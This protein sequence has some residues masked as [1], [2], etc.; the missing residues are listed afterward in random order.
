MLYWK[1]GVSILYQDGPTGM[2]YFR[3]G[4]ELG[5]RLQYTAGTER[6]LSGIAVGFAVN[7]KPDSALVYI[8]QAIPW[9]K[10]AGENKRLSLAYIN[11]ADAYSLLSDFSAAL[12]ACDTALFYANQLPAKEEALGH[13][14]GIISKIYID[15][16]QYALAQVNLEKSIQNFEKTTNRRMV[17]QLY[18]DKADLYNL[19][20]QPAKALPWL[21]EATRIGDSLNDKENLTAYHISFI[22]TYA[23]LKRYDDARNAARQAILI[24]DETDN[25][26]QKANVYLNLCE[27]EKTNNNYQLA[28]EYGERAYEIYVQ[29][30]DIETQQLASSLLT[31]LYV[32]L[33]NTEQAQKYLKIHK[34]LS[35][36]LMHRRYTAE[37]ARLQNSF[38]VKEK[39]KEIQLLSKEKE[40]QAQRLQQ[41]RLLV[42]GGAVLTVLVL[43]GAWLLYNRNKMRQR[44]KELELRNRIAADLHDEVGS[45]LSSIHMLSQ[46]IS[47]K[48]GEGSHHDIL[49]IMSSNAQETMEKMGDIVWMIKPG[50]SES[51]SLKQKMESFMYEVGVAKNIEMIRELDDLNMIKLNMQQRRNIYLIFKEA[52][53]N[54]A[55][56]SDTDKIYVSCSFKNRELQLSVTDEG[57]GF[58]QD[59]NHTGNGLNNMKRRA[60]ELGGHIDIESAPGR[61]TSITLIIPGKKLHKG[62]SDTIQ[63]G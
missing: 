59:L 24:C 49:A 46:M 2:E 10:K 28:A 36:T 32:Q 1:T 42:I 12:K 33:K 31:E 52:V 7:A 30:E 45:S 14:Y 15:H 48:S 47:Q 38:E 51:A 55:K 57:K 21:K 61:G 53:N 58:E 17:A 26:R 13:I 62:D 8:R 4:A 19:Q 34:D 25:Q 43:A 22:Q 35:D 20:E 18:S 60:A 5:Q 16:S 63:S 27:L 9:A 37:T 29:I 54:A 50:E 6:C 41:Q 39:D 56:Y 40:L 23:K 11:L 3:K 44:M